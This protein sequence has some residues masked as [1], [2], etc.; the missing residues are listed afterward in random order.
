[1]TQFTQQIV[2]AAMCFWEAMLDARSE[3]TAPP[4]LE[5]LWW[6][7]GTSAMRLRCLSLAPAI[8][9]L[10]NSLGEDLQEDLAPFDWE[11]CP[12][13]LALMPDPATLPTIEDLKRALRER[14]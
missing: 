8:Q 9:N 3:G 11:F 4:W 12:M 1:M 10:W 6:G 2:E 7:E 14:K 13:V 5:E